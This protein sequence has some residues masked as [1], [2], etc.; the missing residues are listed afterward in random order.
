LR[1]WTLASPWYHPG[2]F[3][4]VEWNHQPALRGLIREPIRESSIR[5]YDPGAK[6]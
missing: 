1:N 3:L 6:L 2:S 4:T 5:E